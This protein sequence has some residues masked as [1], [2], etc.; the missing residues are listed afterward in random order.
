MSSVM[1]PTAVLAVP[2]AESRP[3]DPNRLVRFAVR[4]DADPG[5]LPRVL[6]L[7]AKRGLVPLS[8]NSRLLGGEVAVEIE[9]TGMVA[10]ESNHVGNCL[11]QIPMVLA[12]TVS[13]RDMAEWNMA[14]WTGPADLPA[15]AE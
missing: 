11:R 1:L 4:A 5:T 10:A 6:E 9:V 12:V 15:A 13:E 8:L 7:F 14:E 2:A 3:T